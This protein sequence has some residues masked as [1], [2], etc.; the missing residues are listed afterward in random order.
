M[1]SFYNRGIIYRDALILTSELSENVTQ[2][3]IGSFKSLNPDWLL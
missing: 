2:F 3:G 1:K